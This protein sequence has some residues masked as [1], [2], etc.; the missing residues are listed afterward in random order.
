MLIGL[1]Y[2]LFMII[3]CFLLGSKKNGKKEDLPRHL[4]L[5]QLETDYHAEED[6]FAYYKLQTEKD[7]KD[8]S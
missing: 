7:P 6:E 5:I 4:R 2:A 1:L 3:C 8:A